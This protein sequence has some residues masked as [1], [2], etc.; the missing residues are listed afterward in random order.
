MKWIMADR[1]LTIT[2]Y[3]EEHEDHLQKRM[4]VEE[5]LDKFT[6]EGCPTIYSNPEPPKPKTNADRIRRMSDEELADE[7]LR[8]FNW[9][10]AVEWDDKRIINWL[11]QETD[12]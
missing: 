9:L 7:I 8:W 2:L 1:V 10:N 12:G 3:D 4:T 6:D 11:K 5:I